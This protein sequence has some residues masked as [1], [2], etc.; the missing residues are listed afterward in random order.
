MLGALAAPGPA[1][2]A[3][4]PPLGAERRLDCQIAIDRVYA[5]RR[6]GEDA[7][8]VRD[9]PRAVSARRA[10]DALLMSAALERIW[11]EPIADADL[12]RE[13][14]RM[15]AAS[16]APAVLAELFAALGGDARL[17]AECLARPRLAERRLRSAW[18]AD[19]RIHGELGARA[20]SERRAMRSA[21]DLDVAS[22]RLRR[23][24]WVRDRRDAG[25]D[26]VVLP[27]GEFDARVRD[28]RGKLGG[29]GG[30]L[31]PGS[32]S[33][34]HEDDRRFWVVALLALDDRR[35]SVATVEWEKRP[36]DDW[37]REARGRI[38]ARERGS[39]FPFRLPAPAAAACADDS[40]RPTADL[41]DPRYW[42]SAVWTGGEMIVFGGMEAVGFVYDDGSRYDPATD[43]WSRLPELGAPA[44][45]YA[46]HALWTG[47]EMIVWG[48]RG[49]ATGA[50]YD[51]VADAWTPMSTA[52]APTPRR[53]STAVWTGTEM[54][55]WGGEGPGG[56]LATGARYRPAT[57]TWTPIAPA[58][59]APR[60]YHAA[61]WTGARMVVW[62]GYDVFIGRL[63]GDG[64]RYDPASDTWSP[65]ATANAPDARG[66]HTAVWTGEEMIVWGGINE[67]AY[68]PS[69][70]R[71]DP[72][73]DS[74]TPT[75]MIDAP[76]LRWFHVAV[77]TGEEMIVQAGN[78][79]VT[80]GGRYD[81]ATDTWTPTSPVN[82][83]DHGEGS[84][85][86]WTGE[87]M[88]VWG[89]LDED[90]VFHFDGGRYDPAL[91]LWHPTGTMNVPT[92]RGLHSGAWTGAEMMVW[93]GYSYG[94]PDTG[95]LYDPA[96]DAWRPTTTTGALA[97][98][99]N[100]TAVWTG[101]G[102]AIW[103]GDPDG[104]PFEPG[105]GALY[106][107]AADSWQQM[108]ITGAPTS[109]YGHTAVWTGAE[110]IVF[111]GIGT[112]TVAKR[113]RPDTDQ[114]TDATT[115]A[116]PGARD[117]HAAV[118][119]GS[120]MIVWGGFINDGTTPTGGRYDP[121]ADHW[122]PTD[123]AGSPITRMWPIGVWSGS[124]MIVWGGYEWLFLGD[125]GDGARYDPATD[126]WAPTTLTGAPEPRVAQGVWTGA[127]LVLWG[128]RNDASGGR[129]DPVAD[130]WLP[131]TLAGA[132]QVLWGG[133]WS[134]V[135]TGA[136][137]IVWGGMGP[138]Q[139]GG[140]YCAADPAATVFADGFE[141][142]G[143]TAW[144]AVV[145]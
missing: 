38:A 46:H 56:N 33:A 124:R 59:L 11:R 13:L 120:R 86:V 12:Q 44:W 100:G 43:T 1:G 113:Y 114:W 14:D 74:W 133:R 84:T 23:S 8:A 58:P 135:W 17:A 53:H 101:A 92:A 76:S 55:V 37:W 121:V 136:E 20:R 81:P 61:V 69:G 16:A 132:P 118:W 26:G 21:A 35:L 96:T 18:A 102:V 93:G 66:Y 2:A 71:Y 88:I 79:G 34:V 10:E 54:I 80:A 6:A 75:S 40:W 106:D 107:P 70:G 41:L 73:A 105:T 31:V 95:A 108:T 143:T 5:R 57:D 122:T 104:V 127:E 49:D 130:A 97:G 103:G 111:G 28:L 25:E 117:H 119:T 7:A 109:R 90:F 24:A 65:V 39:D 72:V 91:D 131:T 9:V 62:G 112:D 77:W 52:N 89:G 47:T 3:T 60:A 51:P 64:A 125:L 36:F 67:P 110:M 29:A 129:Y 139:R 126:Q 63:Y 27:P 83:A 45:R 141:S 32:V 15:A 68:E 144:S 78:F 138:T 30:H 22:G 85:A 87:E 116:A 42:H 142:G 140:R 123:V 82:S 115:L 145:P 50:R 99:E 134:T 4:T 94:Y 137:M 19:E 48:G 128:G 98:R